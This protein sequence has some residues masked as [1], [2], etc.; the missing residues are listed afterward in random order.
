MKYFRLKAGTCKSS[1]S[2]NN[3][4]GSSGASSSSGAAAAAASVSKSASVIQFIS[5]V[6]ETLFGLRRSVKT[7]SSSSAPSHEDRH[8]TGEAAGSG[9]PVPRVQVCPCVTNFYCIFLGFIPPNN[10]FDHHM[11]KLYINLY[12][13]SPLSPTIHRLSTILERFRHSHVACLSIYGL[14]ALQEY[15]CYLFI[16]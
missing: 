2:N 7:G 11:C 1:S 15:F 16:P 5:I 3:A 14:A 13:Y 4:A 8:A 12:F 6:F 10:T 9:V